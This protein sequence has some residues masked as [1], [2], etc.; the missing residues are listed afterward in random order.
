M[1]DS[2]MSQQILDVLHRLT[3][4]SP[5]RTEAEVQAALAALLPT[6]SLGLGVHDIR[7]EAPISQA[8]AASM[9]RL[10][11]RSSKSNETCVQRT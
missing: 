4:R 11:L 5:T 8:D 7:L 3:T 1:E 2:R 10:V 6:A 9:S